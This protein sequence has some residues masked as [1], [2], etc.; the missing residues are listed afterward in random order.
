MIDGTKLFPPLHKNQKSNVRHRKAGQ[1]T[2]LAHNDIIGRSIAS[3]YL[4]ADGDSV[5]KIEYPNLD[6]YVSLTPRLVTPVSSL[7][8][9]RVSKADENVQV[10]A[11][12]ASSIVSLLDFHVSSSSSNENARILEPE[13]E[14]LEAGTGHGSLTLHLARAIAAA[15]PLPPAAQW[16]SSTEEKQSLADSQIQQ[17]WNDWRKRRNAVLHTVERYA[18]NSAHAE[19]IVRGYKQG[20]YRPHVDFYVGDVT[21]WVNQ[22]LE[23]RKSTGLHSS[24]NQEK[25]FLS[26]VIL[27][28][29]NVFKHVGGVYKGLRKDG[30][31]LVFA[32]SIT[33]I[34]DCVRTIEEQKLP[35]VLDQVVELGEGISNGRRWD[36]RLVRPRGSKESRAQNEVEA[37]RIIEP[38]DTAPTSDLESSEEVHTQAAPENVM[39]C[40]PKVGERIMG[41]GFVGLWNRTSED[42][43]ADELLWREPRTGEFFFLYPSKSY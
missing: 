34:G 24:L 35:F 21:D 9:G 15:N 20:L 36:V 25:G 42:P 2:T 18:T 17:A 13:I 8:L 16:P 7:Y 29:P 37:D 38:T 11:S 32:P 19:K 43:S 12:Y 30:K 3:L 28:L 23:D 1:T 33:Q 22:Q 10:Y 5:H 40:R 39:V 31:L 14:I 26:H 6:Q 41:G 27:D 4:R